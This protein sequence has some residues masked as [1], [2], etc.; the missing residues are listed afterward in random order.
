[1]SQ[2]WVNRENG[3]LHAFI[4]GE[5]LPDYNNVTHYLVDV[6]E[7]FWDGLYDWDIGSRTFINITVQAPVPL[8]V[9]PLQMR[10]AIRQQGLKP[11]VDTFLE[12]LDEE[13]VEAWEYATSI[14]RDNEF[15]TL[16]LTGLGWTE[17]QADD[18]FR[19]ADSL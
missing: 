16:A 19:L 13:V 11:T 17:T 6:P 3:L 2:G 12:T 1:M 18:L 4:E 10:K 9:T 7:G 15:I 8:S 5:T 14:E